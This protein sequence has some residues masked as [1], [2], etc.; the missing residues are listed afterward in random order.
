MKTPEQE[1]GHEGERANLTGCMLTIDNLTLFLQDAGVSVRN[2]LLTKETDVSG[3]LDGYS[4]TNAANTLPSILSD[5]FKQNGMKGCGT[6][7]VKEFLSCI[8]D[9][10][11]YN[12]V[13]EYLHAQKWDGQDRLPGLYA[14]L[15][16]ENDVRYQTYLRKWLLQCVAL[17]KN[18]EQNPIGAEGVL[19]LLGSQGAGKTSF[20]RKLCPN[21]RWFAEGVSIDIRDKDSQIR[22][23]GSWICELGELDATTKK[24]QPALKAFLTAAEDRI[25]LPY[26]TAPTRTARHTSFCGTVN[27]EH[28]LRDTTG[29]RRYWTIPVNSMRKD[30]VFA[31][32]RD[33]VD[34]LWAQ[35]FKIYYDNPAGFRL[36]DA[37]MRQLQRDNHDFEAPL[38]YETELRELFDFDMPIADWQWWKTS[39]LNRVGLLI[40]SRGDAAK[41]GRACMKIAEEF[42]SKNYV[43]RAHKTV[44]GTELY[45]FPIRRFTPP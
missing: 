12:P 34:Q 30:M 35:M 25:R 2:N 28:F 22:A 10:G 41:A 40:T 26:D 32:T 4:Q 1:K 33:S 7:R 18:D 43:S 37:E 8:A 42:E 21:P 24:E 31:L 19:V 44:H 36:T 16:I 45:L 3:R 13:V 38:P 17:A 23:L 20:F 14:T 6:A 9:F 29:S 39:E 27:D 11:R 5:M 15:G